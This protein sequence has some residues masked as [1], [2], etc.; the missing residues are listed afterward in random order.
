MSLSD[1][2]IVGYTGA[3]DIPL[4]AAPDLPLVRLNR[5]RL[6]LLLRNCHGP[7]K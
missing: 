2:E 7:M 5:S 4:H 1:L 3:A 6:R